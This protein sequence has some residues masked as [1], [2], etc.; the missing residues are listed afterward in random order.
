M[1]RLVTQKT[2]ILEEGAFLEQIR[3]VFTKLSKL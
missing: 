1:L 2:K 3:K